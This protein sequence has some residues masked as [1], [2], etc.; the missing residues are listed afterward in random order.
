MPTFP[1]LHALR[2]EVDAKPIVLPI[3]GREF[4]FSRSIPMRTGLALAEAQVVAKQV[5]AALAEGREPDDLGE[6]AYQSVTED[7]AMR[8]LIGDQWQPLL[9]AGCTA[10]EVRHVYL[11]LFTWHMAGEAAAEL[12]WTEGLPEGDVGPPARSASTD[13]RT[14]RS[15]S[16]RRSS[17]GTG[18]R[19]RVRRSGGETSSRRGS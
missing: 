11:T 12:V 7:Q 1:E 9:D 5:A 16:T 4:R 17:S 14:S 2:S 3:R 8:D 10:A 15:S 18:R 6:A 19:R 13:R